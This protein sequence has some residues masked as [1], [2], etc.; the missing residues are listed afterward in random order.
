MVHFTH[1]VIIQGIIII[2]PT[3]IIEAILRLIIIMPILTHRAIMLD[4]GFITTLL[5]P[6]PILLAPP[7]LHPIQETRTHLDTIQERILTPL[8]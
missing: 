1:L 5:A 6:L 8:Q 2:L 4:M 3:A 7:E